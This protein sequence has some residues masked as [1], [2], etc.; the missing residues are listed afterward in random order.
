MKMVLEYPSVVPLGNKSVFATTPMSL[1]TYTGS[2]GSIYVP[3]SLV[4][5]YK[6]AT[7]WAT[8]ADR[9]TAIVKEPTLI[10]FT[11]GE[12]EYQAEEGMTWEEW[13]NS[14]YNTGVFYIDNNCIYF[15]HPTF[16]GRCYVVDDTREIIRTDLIIND[17]AYMWLTDHSGNGGGND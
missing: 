5:A 16:S 8:Y 4:D 6:S 3:A 1:S 17:Y 11:V 13:V 15:P 12:V 2:F 7:N 10:S 14:T 9:I